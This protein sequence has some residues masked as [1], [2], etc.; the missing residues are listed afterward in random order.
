MRPAENDCVDLIGATL[1]S[2]GSSLRGQSGTDFKDQV[3]EA[4]Q[5]QPAVTQLVAG[6]R[7]VFPVC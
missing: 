5:E 2:P 7:R 6:H 4:E 1:I 3:E